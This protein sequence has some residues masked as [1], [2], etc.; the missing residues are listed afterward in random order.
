MRETTK[1]VSIYVEKKRFILIKKSGF[2]KRF[3]LFNYVTYLKIVLSYNLNE[4][5]NK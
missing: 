4:K 1:I 5:L 2:I 3:D